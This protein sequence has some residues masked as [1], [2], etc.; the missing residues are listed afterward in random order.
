MNSDPAQLSAT[1]PFDRNADL[2]T[3]GGQ[4]VAGLK[5]PLVSFIVVNWNYGHFLGETLDSIRNQHYPSLECVVVDNGSTDDSVDVFERHVG[6]DSRFR[7][8]RLS[9]NV[10]Q[11]GGA[12]VGFRS[13]TGA[14]IAI[15]DADDVLF[16]DFTAVHV[17]T[18]LALIDTVALTTSNV[19]ETDTENRALS[20][21]CWSKLQ[22][23]TDGKSVL[24]D[25]TTVARIPQL[26]AE[27]YRSTLMPRVA[28]ADQ[29]TKGWLWSPGTSN[30]M[31]RSVA[32]LFLE[33][34][35]VQM[36]PADAYFLKLC[37]AFGGTAF[38]DLPLSTRRIHG[39]NYF[40]TREIVSDIR[41]VARSF[42]DSLKD[43][44]IPLKRINNV[45]EH[46]QSNYWLLGWRYWEALDTL[47]SRS[48]ISKYRYYN[49]ADVVNVF[50]RHAKALRSLGSRH[51][52]IWA[53]RSRFNLSNSIRIVRAGFDGRL[54]AQFF[55][56][57]MPP[58]PFPPR[59][60]WRK[61][62][63]SIL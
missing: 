51:A 62:I 15:I 48:Y 45:L 61:I 30:V 25:E 55:I 57:L 44:D 60:I 23:A 59:G 22:R 34:E 28:R 54:P 6:D 8:I 18:H 43:V 42:Q 7:L 31:R 5:T 9:E 35:R 49:S 3:V 37:H 11:L 4:P 19:I 63:R 58:V 16:P 14:F 12:F 56:W 10:G 17:Q 27:F 2:M 20:S 53:I 1:Q 13:A 39:D 26:S 50:C 40:A 38:V 29:N 46:A 33:E 32:E 52:F 36:M 47:T 21:S 41:V 24:R